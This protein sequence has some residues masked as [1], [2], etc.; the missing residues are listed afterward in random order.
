MK[1]LVLSAALA[2]GGLFLVVSGAQAHTYAYKCTGTAGELEAR[3]NG[4]S[5]WTS[6][7]GG[8]GT[9][10]PIASGDI[11]EIDGTTNNKS[12]V[13]DIFVSVTGVTFKNKNGSDVL[14]APDQIDGMFEVAGAHITIDAIALTC[15]GCSSSTLSGSGFSS[16]N[17]DAALVLHDG[18][19][20]LVENAQINGSKTSGIFLTRNAAISLINTTI[21][22]NGLSASDASFASGIFAENR[23]SVSLGKPDGTGGVFIAGNGKSGGG[24]PGFGIFLRTGST[25]DAFVGGLGGDST[26]NNAGGQNTCG[27]IL[28][29]SG[30]SA[31]IQ[32]TSLTQTTA[33]Q[34]AVQ[35]LSGSSFIATTGPGPSLTQISAGD[36]GAVLLGGASSAVLNFGL[37][38]STGTSV[39]TIEA[40][41]G[42]TV[43]LASNNLLSNSTSGGIV[44]QIDHS[45][46]LT[47]VPGQLFGFTFTGPETITGSAFIQ[48][49]SSMDIGIGLLG[50]GASPSMSWTVPSGSCIL[51]QQN[52]SF[53]M[54][55]G[56][57]IAGAAAAPCALNGGAVSTTIVFQQESNGFF[58]LSRGGTDAISGGGVSCLFAGMPNAHITGKANISPAGAQP[59]IIGSWSAANPATSPGCLGP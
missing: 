44:F 42:S 37:I 32:G 39:A 23:S 11:V 35:A 40:T 30:S 17:E 20:V 19:V 52:S 55:G 49:Q 56:V 7:D 45:S 28:L 54:S 43:T 31:L 48:V 33:S 26:G 13:G 16:F 18:A 29:Q 3:I 10:A 41:G 57:A 47:Q 24:C 51:V 53:R 27:Q 14:N 6:T 8:A 58:N 25:L 38:Q 9:T 46:S 12:C 5:A 4:S 36:S 21:A 59:V 2:L 22:G 1:E 15:T 50:G 34:P